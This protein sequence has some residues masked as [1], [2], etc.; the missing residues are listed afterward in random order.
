MAANGGANVDVERAYTD[1]HEVIGGEQPVCVGQWCC[2]CDEHPI[3]KP[4]GASF[5]RWERHYAEHHR[6]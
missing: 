3:G 2:G 1:S 4:W 6:R 5:E